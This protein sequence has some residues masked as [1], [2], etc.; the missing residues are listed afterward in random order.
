MSGKEINVSLK[1]SLESD[2]SLTF[3]ERSKIVIGGLG[4][5]ETLTSPSERV[6]IQLL[7]AQLAWLRL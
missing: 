6:D 5:S 2:S 3:G 7:L 1:K 4:M